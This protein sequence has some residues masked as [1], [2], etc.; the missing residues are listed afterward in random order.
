MTTLNKLPGKRTAVIAAALALCIAT[1]TVSSALS[2]GKLRSKTLSGLRTSN[3][4]SL[5]NTSE[6]SVKDYSVPNL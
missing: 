2:N 6:L 3:V 5:N 4:V 1:G